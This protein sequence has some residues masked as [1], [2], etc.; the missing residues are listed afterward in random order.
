M[1]VDALRQMVPW[2]FALDHVHYARWMSVFSQSLLALPIKHSDIYNEFQNGRFTIQKTQR[3]FSRIADDQ[4]HERNDEV[5]KSVGGAVGIFESPKALMNWMVARPDVARMISDFEAILVTN[6]ELNDDHNNHHENTSAFEKRFRKHV[7]A[8]EQSFIKEGNPFEEDENVLMTIVSRN[9]MSEKAKESVYQATELGKRQYAE[10]VQMR[11]H[12]G[13]MS[14]YN[15]IKKNKLIL[16]RNKNSIVTQKSKIKVSSLKDECK[17]YASL[18]VACQTREGDLNDFFAHENHSFPPALSSYGKLRQTT[19][20][21]GIKILSKLHEPL[22]EEQDVTAIALDGA[23]I[24]QM[25]PPRTSKTMGQYCENE[26]HGFLQRYLK[27]PTVSRLDLVFDRYKDRSIK[28]AAREKRGS[29]Q[30]IRVEETTPVPK[31]WKSFLRVN[32]NKQ[33]LFKLIGQKVTAQPS[34]KVIFATIGSETKASEEFQDTSQISPCNHEEADT[35][36]F[37]HVKYQADQG[38]RKISIKTVDTDFVVIGISL[39]HDLNVT[40]LWI[41]FGTGK[42]K[43]WL[44]VHA[45]TEKLG[46]QISRAFGFW[47]G[48][49]GCDTVSSF[50]SRGKIASWETSKAFPEITSTFLPLANEPV[51]LQEA[52]CTFIERFVSLLYCRTTELTEVN[53]CRRWLFTTKSRSVD[54]IPHQKML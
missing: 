47:H 42:D 34:S 37:L 23:A 16:F 27:K 48:F 35:R 33:E 54:N 2:A 6:D 26:M 43:K 14:I 22:Y 3:R 12:I 5:I 21:D 38:H 4:A 15:T 32:E 25:V 44:P 9:I 1:F 10:F 8:L 13:E 36:L 30:R 24:V 45:Y 40:E 28:A 29:G 18:Y 46:P 31:N 49:T 19:K 51:E 39:F 52:E 7:N 50:S 53:K 20:S 11:L 41:E 17:L